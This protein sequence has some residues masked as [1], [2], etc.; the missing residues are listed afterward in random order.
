MTTLEHHANIVPW[1]LACERSGATLKVVPLNERGD[2]DLSALDELLTP[3]TKLF[4]F[5]QISNALGVVNP[6]EELIKAAKAKGIMTLVD[7]AQGAAH[8]HVDV[9]ALGCD[10]YVFSGH[11]L[12]GPTGVGI[13]YGRTEVLEAL[14][15]YQGGGDM[16]EVVT[17]EKT[18]YAGLPSRLEA[19]TPNIAGA[20]GL[21]VA[22]EYLMS[23]DLTRVERYEAELVAYLEA[24]LR[25]INKVR[26]LAEPRERASAV[27]FVVEG[28]HPH[29]IGVL[30]DNYGVAV[31]VGHHCAQPVMSALNVDSTVRAS[32]GIYTTREDIDQLLEALPKVIE[33]LA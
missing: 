9:Q 33:M 2:L 11:K 28:A 29:D 7:G 30:L 4:A 6:T 8:T 26:V 19:G 32:V 24:G 23:F 20:V 25:A 5:G 27:S 12:Y 15:P 18:T 3:K 17:F 10:F 22:L 14:P 1:Q 31:R 16:I 21:G 13:L